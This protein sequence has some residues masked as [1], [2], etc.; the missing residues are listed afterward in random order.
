MAWQKLLFSKLISKIMA[1]RQ[2]ARNNLAK[3]LVKQ[4]LMKDYGFSQELIEQGIV[5]Y[6]VCVYIYLIFPN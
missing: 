3:D 6:N 5:L 2:F 4:T 1:A